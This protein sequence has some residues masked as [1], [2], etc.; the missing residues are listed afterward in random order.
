MPQLSPA[1]IDWF[2]ANAR[3]IIWRDN[4]TTAWGILVSEVMSQ[5]TPVRR[6][7][8]KWQQWLDRWP[9]PADLAAAP[10]DE[11]LKA[12]DNLGYPRRALRLK[13]C[14]QQIVEKH[15]GAV[16]ETVD[17]LLALPGIGDY[18]A[19]AVCAFAF[20]QRVPVIDV[21]IRRVISRA[22]HGTFLPRSTA[23]SKADLAFLENL[24][25]AVDAASY[26][27]ALMEL[28]ALV[29]TPTP[30]CDNCPINPECAWQQ[31]GCPPPSD[32]ELSQAKRR[33]QK[34]VGTDRQVRGIIMAELRAATAPVPT[35]AIDILWPEQHQL[36]RALY[37]LLEDGLIEETNSGFKLPS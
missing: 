30:D 11:V 17:E 24:L 18:T 6:V 36:H 29:C 35:T 26:C 23:T 33:V 32:E 22:Y 10:T 20:K 34:F 27:A 15:D 37:S 1:L 7:E 12:W 8:P 28:G 2:N 9:T 4:P 16:P 13:E 21:N 19:R 3:P 5:Q 31:A 25:P 14:A